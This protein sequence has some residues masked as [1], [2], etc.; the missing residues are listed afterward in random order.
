MDLQKELTQ[1][2]EEIGG[3]RRVN[4]DDVLAALGL[5]KKSAATDYVLPSLGIFGLGMVVGAGLGLLL[6]PRTGRATRREI[7]K[8]IEGVA[9]RAKDVV[10]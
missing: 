1:K 10:S 9:E 4:K 3:L 8:K 5:E 7:G 2:L 6:A